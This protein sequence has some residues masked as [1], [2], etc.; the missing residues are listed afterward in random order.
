MSGGAHLSG[1]SLLLVPMGKPQSDVRA[2][3]AVLVIYVTCI[4]LGATADDVAVGAASGHGLELGIAQISAGGCVGT[5]LV[6]REGQA[7]ARGDRRQE[8]LEHGLVRLGALVCLGGGGELRLQPLVFLQQLFEP[9]D[10]L[11]RHGGLLLRCPMR[12]LTVPTIRVGSG[13]RPA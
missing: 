9:L 2:R 1:S 5:G 10:V 4:R 8:P 3:A 7:G 13:R 11:Q 6:K 12:L